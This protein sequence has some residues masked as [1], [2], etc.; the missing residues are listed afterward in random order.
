MEKLKDNRHAVQINTEHGINSLYN[1]FGLSHEEK[2]TPK[3]L[4]LVISLLSKLFQTTIFG[5][6]VELF[7]ATKMNDDQA[8]TSPNKVFKKYIF[9]L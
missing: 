3:I 9:T 4:S 7:H 2:F 1:V 8:L 6:N 5:Q